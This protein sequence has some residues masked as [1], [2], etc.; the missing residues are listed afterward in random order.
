MSEEL[1][2]RRQEWHDRGLVDVS[3]R[4]PEAANYK[5]ELV[6]RET[7]VRV[8]NKMNDERRQRG[9]RRDSTEPRRSHW[10]RSTALIQHHDKE[11]G[12]PLRDDSS[13]FELLIL[14]G[15]QAG[16]VAR[17]KIGTGG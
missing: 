17:A 1:R 9:R 15:A 6:S 12:V 10:A 16:F 14:K 2:A 3:P 7:V 4:R 11:W 5:I 13:L 8:R